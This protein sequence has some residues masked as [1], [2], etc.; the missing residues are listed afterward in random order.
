MKN[1]PGP[2]I[3]SLKLTL[4]VCKTRTSEIITVYQ[5]LL[6]LVSTLNVKKMAL[7]RVFISLN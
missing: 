5:L 4:S 3:Q 2:G 6:S 7:V 1:G